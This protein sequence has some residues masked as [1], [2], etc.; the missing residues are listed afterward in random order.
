MED[1]SST[2]GTRI[3]D[4]G[5]AE[6][7]ERSILAGFEID[8]LEI[9][10][11]D[12]VPGLSEDALA[13][14]ADLYDEDYARLIPGPHQRGPWEWDMLSVLKTHLPAG[15]ASGCDHPEQ[16]QELKARCSPS[17]RRPPPRRR[18]R[19]SPRCAPRASE[20]SRSGGRSAS[21]DRP[22]LWPVHAVVARS[23]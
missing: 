1:D 9:R 10:D 18:R 21:A 20:P 17:C 3:F 6:A 2:Y 22:R 5:L 19:R 23:R 12:P 14:L 4:L 8:V 7:V 15:D 11:P 16:R 13:L